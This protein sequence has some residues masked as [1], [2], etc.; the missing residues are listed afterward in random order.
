VHRRDVLTCEARLQE[1]LKQSGI[2]VLW[3]SEIREILGDKVVKSVKIEDKKSGTTKEMPVDG[4]FVGIGYV[5]SNDMARQL[6]LELDVQGYIK[7]DLTTMRTSLPRVYTAGDIT[8]A[9]KQI[10]V[11]VSQG[12][13]AAMT[14]FEDISSMVWPPTD[15][16]Q[17]DKAEEAKKIA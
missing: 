13:I 4:V 7:T 14:A 9:P 6:G 8:G 12:S 2:P 3:N 16:P 5:P 15:K 10:V 17:V 1:T 11:A